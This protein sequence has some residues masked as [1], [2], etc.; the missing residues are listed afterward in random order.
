MEV[1]FLQRCFADLGLESKGVSKCKTFKLFSRSLIGGG[2]SVTSEGGLVAGDRGRHA[3]APLWS[4]VLLGEQA[5]TSHTAPRQR[6][7]RPAL[8]PRT[9]RGLLCVSLYDLGQCRSLPWPCP[10]SETGGLG[11]MSSRGL[12]ALAFSE[13]GV[14]DPSH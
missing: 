4:Q 7:G 5:V 3:E 9:P 14:M 6:P 13:W 8:W 2:A 10:I 1:I 11:F 12:L